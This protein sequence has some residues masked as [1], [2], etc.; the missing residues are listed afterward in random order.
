MTAADRREIVLDAAVQEFGLGGYHGTSAEA[1]ARR[2]GISQPYLF[3]LFGTK[4]ELFLAVVDLTFDRILDALQQAAEHSSTEEILP[5]LWRAYMSA[6]A[7]EA[8]ALVQIQAFAAC[9]DD[10]I[11]FVVRRR[12]ADCYRFVDSVARTD[13]DT[14]RAFF[15]E[16]MLAVAT[17]SM[18]LPELASRERWV[19]VL[20]PR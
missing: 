10:E 19:R 12:F 3:R 14:V 6:M 9:G 2:A 1:I 8:G 7:G 4:R 16:A 20:L 13:E 18:R 17:T 5:S 11:R 15:A